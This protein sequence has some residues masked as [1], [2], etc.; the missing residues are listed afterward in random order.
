VCG[1]TQAK[2]GELMMLPG[3]GLGSIIGGRKWK[4]AYVI[5]KDGFIE[6]CE[7]KVTSSLTF[8]L[9]FFLL[10]FSFPRVLTACRVCARACAAV[11]GVC[12]C[13]G[14]NRVRSPSC[15]CR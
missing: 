4:K 9:M 15:V 14:C 2:E 13:I 6:R 8:V 10:L 1:T 11:C 12:G 5:V 3:K 7:A